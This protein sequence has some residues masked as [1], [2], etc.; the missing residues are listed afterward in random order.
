MIVGWVCGF[1]LGS[2]SSAWSVH[3]YFSFLKVIK[4]NKKV[5]VPLREQGQKK[6]FSAVPPCLPEI[7]PL[8]TAPTRR[9]P[10]NAGNASED[11]LVTHFPLPSAAHLLPRFSLCSQLCRTLCGCALQLYFRFVG[12][13]LCYALYTPFVYVCQELFFAERGL[14]S[15]RFVKATPHNLTRRLSQD[16]CPNSKVEKWRNTACI[17]H[18]SS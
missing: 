8:C 18:F 7:R 1:F 10:V 12:F 5:L 14:F 4:G 11:T 6:Q 9:L 17:S 16:F 13:D 2:P 15:R 3:R